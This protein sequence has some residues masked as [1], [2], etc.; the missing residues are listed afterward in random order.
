MAVQETLAIMR[1]QPLREEFAAGFHVALLEHRMRQAMRRIGVGR[2]QLHRAFAQGASF[3][4]VSRFG[5][6]PAE[7]AGEPPVLAVVR[8]VTQ[9][10]RE[11]GGV[12]VGAT[13]EGIE[14]EGA[15]QQRQ[16]QRVARIFVQ[17]GL[18]AVDGNFRL[19]LDHGGH[20]LDMT[21][22]PRRRAA[23]SSRA[24]AAMARASLPSMLS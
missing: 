20:D 8:G 11:L 15:E 6:R 14:A 9:A 18:G 17:M 3:A 1:R 12:M 19:A 22:F 2:S 5:M 7:I 4:Q 10:D 21:D 13:R 16:H 23:A 24:R